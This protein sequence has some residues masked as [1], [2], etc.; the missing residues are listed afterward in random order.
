MNEMTF[1][2]IPLKEMM[3]QIWIINEGI[4]KSREEIQIKRII[5]ELEDCNIRE[6]NKLKDKLIPKERM[7]W[8]LNNSKKTI[9]HTSD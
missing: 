8:S 7:I 2:K 5:E 9:E 1:E 6:I 3:Y 4:L